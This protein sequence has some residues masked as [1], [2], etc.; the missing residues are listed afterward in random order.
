[1]RVRVSTG[2]G[3]LGEATSAHYG[4]VAGRFCCVRPARR[5]SGSGGTWSRLLRSSSAATPAI[6]PPLLRGSL[7]LRR[8]CSRVIPRS[9]SR[10][11]CRC[12]TGHRRSRFDLAHLARPPLDPRVR[13]RFLCG[14][15]FPFDRVWGG[16]RGSP[17]EELFEEGGVAGIGFED[18]HGDVAHKGDETDPE[19]AELVC[20]RVV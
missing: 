12:R 1:M 14:C 19:T 18:G 5:R 9:R 8:M 20:R 10:S 17:D 11:G 2:S 3:S 6:P 13:D 15:F 7:I 16:G 4:G